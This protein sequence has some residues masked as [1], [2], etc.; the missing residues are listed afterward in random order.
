MLTW[1]FIVLHQQIL[2]VIVNLK[3]PNSHESLNYSKRLGVGTVLDQGAVV[4]ARGR[5]G[6]GGL[7]LILLQMGH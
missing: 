2:S 6:C 5:C 4:Y 7:G 3:L 1:L